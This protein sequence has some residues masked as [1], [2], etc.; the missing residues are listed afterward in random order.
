MA[1]K[2]DDGSQV[3]RPGHDAWIVGNETCVVCD[4][5]GDAVYAKMRRR[6]E[7]PTLL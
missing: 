3:A 4:F 7:R 2:M 5:S 1:I 6:N